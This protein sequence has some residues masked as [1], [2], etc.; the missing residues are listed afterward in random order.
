MSEKVRFDIVRNGYDPTQVN[1]VIDLLQN[2]ITTLTGQLNQCVTQMKA[3]NEQYNQV[4]GRYQTIV[5]ELQMREK[6]ADEVARLTLKE[7]NTVI[8]TARKNADAITQEA[9]VTARSLIANAQLY[10][11]QAQAV[12]KYLINQL[13]AIIEQLEQD[14]GQKDQ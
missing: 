2:Q 9:V 11:Q 4:N 3:M 6:A 14:Q 13:E 10:N 8:D 12:K 7:A 5:S 1:K